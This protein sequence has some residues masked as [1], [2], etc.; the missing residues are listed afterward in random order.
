MYARCIFIYLI[1]I[2]QNKNC[3]KGG[4]IAYGYGKVLEKEHLFNIL[5]YGRMMYQ[6]I[7]E[8][9]NLTIHMIDDDDDFF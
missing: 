8:A 9:I 1:F 5:P 3:T 7:L 2:A 4:L 6:A